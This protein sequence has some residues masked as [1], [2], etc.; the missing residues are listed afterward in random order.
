MAK[1]LGGSEGGK[2]KQALLQ[3]LHEPPFSPLPMLLLELPPQQRTRG[4][5]GAF[6]RNLRLC[7]I[8]APRLE[9]HSLRSAPTAFSDGIALH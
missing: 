3:A 2:A 1:N 9:S 8:C 7:R 5:L 4:D 6:E